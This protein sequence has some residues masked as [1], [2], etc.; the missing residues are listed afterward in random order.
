MPRENETNQDEPPPPS[1][2]AGKKRVAVYV[3]PAVHKRLKVMSTQ[4][5]QPIVHL[6]EAWLVEKTEAWARDQ[7]VRQ[8]QQS[9]DR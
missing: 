2:Y 1:A 3:A 5:E 7:R 4:L 8:Q 9:A 6:V